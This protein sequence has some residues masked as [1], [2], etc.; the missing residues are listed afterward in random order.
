MTKLA[1]LV[2]LAA[3]TASAPTA[4]ECTSGKCD[5]DGGVDQACN[6][7]RYDDGKCDLDLTC[8]D[9]DI[10]CYR[11]FATDAEA[12]TWWSATERAE[13]GQ[14]YPIVPES[15]PR[16]V[17]VRAALDKGWE[18]FKLNRPVGK[19][20]D[21][22]PALVV[23]DQPLARAAFV[24]T[25]SAAGNQ[26]FAVMVETAGLES[27]ADDDALLGVMMHELQHAVGLH[28]LG[29]NA[30]K[31][32]KF[33]AAHAGTEPMG[34]DQ[35]DDADLRYVGEA[36]MD[37]ATE[38]GPYSQ[39]ELGG[40]PL[41]GDLHTILSAAI[42]SGQGSHAAAC[43]P[44]AMRI[45]QITSTV[46]AAAD[47][48]DGAL[49]DL[50]G[51]DTAVSDALD[52]LATDCLGD[53]PYGFIEVGAALAN[54]TPA[55]FEAH[56]DAHDLALVKGVP[57]VTGLTALVEDRR[58]TMRTAEQLFT[59]SSHESWNQLRY[60][61]VEEDADDVSTIVMHGAGLDPTS[62][63]GFFRAVLPVPS[64]TACDNLLADG[65]PGYGVDLTDPHHA[66]C[67]RIGHVQREA[68]TFRQRPVA[69]APIPHALHK[70][71]KLPKKFDPASQI[72]D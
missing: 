50:T 27:G 7:P 70:P 55:E 3:C 16:F 67:W 59:E 30:S 39:P 34:R 31:L 54:I 45:D 51:V 12:A 28:N 41:E 33:Y 38:V 6:D 66:V 10:D 17:R 48:L 68:K 14:M 13:L 18:A 64:R 32:R 15:D 4:P 36:W 46:L 57:F 9:P 25:D 8:A 29:N 20:A 5:G 21:K 58:D 40:L 42:S 60:F 37:A 62:V 52:A 11:T 63:A 24:Y 19:L 69:H 35:H 26:P 65:L 49:P 1:P 53:F 44:V 71:G 2:L 47:P 43:D 61:S 72:L 23:V 22:R 56:L